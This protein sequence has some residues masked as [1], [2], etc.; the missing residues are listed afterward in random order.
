MIK[1]L[2][3]L[4]HTLRFLK[5]IQFYWRLYLKINRFF[6]F[7]YVID[8]PVVINK[9][10]LSS[11][12]AKHSSYL[13][14]Q[15]YF[16]NEAGEGRLPIN[17]DNDQSS[18][19]W[20]YNLHYFDYLNQ[21]EVDQ[22]LVI[23]LIND[24]VKKNPVGKGNGW[25][26][27]T[28][29]LR[30]VNWIKFLV[31]T[32]TDIDQNRSLYDSLFVQSRFL[33]KHLEYH[34]LGNHL[35]KNAVALIFAGVFFEGDEAKNWLDKGRQIFLA[36]IREQVLAD[37]G[38]F[39]RSPMYHELIL[40]DILDCLNLNQ[41]VACFSESETQFIS[42]K[43]SVMLTFLTDILHPDGEIPFFNDSALQIAP[44]PLSIF[45]Y[46]ASLAIEYTEVDEA[47]NCSYIEKLEFG[48]FVLQCPLSKMIFD[49][50][51]IGPGYLPGHAH[52]DTLSYELSIAGKRC[53]VNCGTYQYAGVE[54]NSFRAT[55]AHSTVRIDS[56]E[57]HEIW[58]TFRV[59]R[60][61]YPIDL[62]ISKKSLAE[63]ECMASHTG[64]KRLAGKP[65]HKRVVSYQ[66]N[67]IFIKDVI[68][69]KGVHLAESFIPLHPEV[70]II[71]QSDTTVECK[72]G[73][74]LFSIQIQDA[75]A[76]DIHKGVYS[77][78]F[79]KKVEIDLLILK[80]KAVCPF[81]FGYKIYF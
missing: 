39:E 20:L 15:F 74:I 61:G 69:G 80:K 27:Y 29:S 38:H 56:V 37:G 2:F 54:R 30:I 51:V 24:W 12:I 10:N 62:S 66:R 79:G 46:A 45:K 41:A 32:N 4:F 55:S 70:E 75:L 11:P 49:V 36:Q 59:A 57:Q 19:L 31:A 43:A 34:L 8:K 68:I 5:P 76:I 9:I 72:R 13:N 64:F 77:A 17:W 50:G 26:P 47:K 1:K 60:R 21:V 6:V 42:A 25:E 16:L 53:I 73:D 28:L 67:K 63:I 65:V 81:S 78:E 35:F 44:S 71:S 33:F 40:E 22:T 14:G 23:G 3:L 48:L 7:S 18:K 58:S 52:C